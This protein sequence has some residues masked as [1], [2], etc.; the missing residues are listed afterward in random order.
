[1]LS[2]LSCHLAYS[3]L[4]SPVRQHLASTTARSLAVHRQQQ[5]HKHIHSTSYASFATSGTSRDPSSSVGH[6]GNKSSKPSN[7]DTD[8]DIIDE[9]ALT[10]DDNL[11]AEKATRD[12]LH[13]ALRS[14]AVDAIRYAYFAQRAD[15]E[16]EVSAAALFKR[17]GASAHEQALGHLELLEEYGDASFMSTMDNIDGMAEHEREM[18]DNVMRRYADKAGEEELEEVEEWFDD[19]ADANLRAA[20]KLEG[21]HAEMEDEMMEEGEGDAEH[22]I[23]EPVDSEKDVEAFNKRRR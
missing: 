10:D 16:C 21:V 9:D 19:V 22:E 23:H 14:R 12:N 17:L 20:N 6:G 13:E 4:R 18:A 7:L 3:A 2:T 5:Q 1:M 15:V 11:L 8:A